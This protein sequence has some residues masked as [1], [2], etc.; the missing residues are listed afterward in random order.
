MNSP[1][2]TRDFLTIIGHHNVVRLKARC[3]Y[4]Y[5][6][7]QNK[8]VW[9]RRLLESNLAVNPRWI[10]LKSVLSVAKGLRLLQSLGSLCSF[11]EGLFKDADAAD[12]S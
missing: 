4:L 5:S 12:K 7:T 3:V 6:V 9:K 11:T 8:D 10:K 1:R 2:F